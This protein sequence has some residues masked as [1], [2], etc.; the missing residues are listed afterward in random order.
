MKLFLS[1]EGIECTG[2]TA[3]AKRLAELAVAGGISCS[4]KPEFPHELD[5]EINDALSRSIFVSQTFRYGAP[6]SLFFMLYGEAVSVFN[7][8]RDVDLVIADRYLDSIAIYQRRFLPASE[9]TTSPSKFLLMLESLAL[10]AGLPIPD[11][12]VW[13]DAPMSTTTERFLK[14]EKRP[15][16]K[17]EANR[18]DTFRDDYAELASSHG[19]F[20]KVDATQDINT[21]AKGI[22]TD[23]VLHALRR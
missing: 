10:A 1:I 21:I 13:L 23:T 2:K 4:V 20:K 9:R 11:A 12:T 5:N 17:D 3:V 19:R 8:N 14:R 22:L 6:A 15:L 16:S 18:I 7:C